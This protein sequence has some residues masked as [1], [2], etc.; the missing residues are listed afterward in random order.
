MA[1]VA[2]CETVR[3]ATSRTKTT[4]NEI[5]SPFLECRSIR[6]QT[7]RLPFLIIVHR[8]IC[9]WNQTGQKHAGESDI[10]RTFLAK[11]NVALWILVIVTLIDLTRRLACFSL[12]RAG[13]RI[14]SFLSIALCFSVYSFKVVFTI[15]DAP[16][17][18]AGIP[19]YLWR[20]AEWTLLLYQARMVFGSIALLVVFN[21]YQRIFRDPDRKVTGSKS[22][23]SL[24]WFLRLLSTLGVDCSLHDLITV[25]LVM[26][27]KLNNVPLFLLFYIELEILGS[28][29][30][31]PVEITLTSILFQHASFFAYGGSNA[32]SSI[33]LSNAYN[34]VSGYNVT[35]VG[36]LTFASNWSGPIWWT[37]ATNLLLLQNRSRGQSGNLTMHITSLTVFTASSLLSVML[38]CT[39][40]RTHLFIWTVFSPRY[41]YSM[42]WSLGQ[43]LCIDVVFGSMLFW[44]GS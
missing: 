8:I 2:L 14:A 16:E 23:G 20:P 18:L 38:A 43:H 33:D 15:A 41:L 37:S 9:R 35:A 5:L 13:P 12:S 4:A 30:L 19:Q 6:Q 24:R 17:L 28:L 42:A 21:L 31:D 11:H 27:T 25:F 40:L 36:L 1:G 7:W 26:Q 39:L 3:L 22:P 29:N 44:I 10:A 32:I 34:G